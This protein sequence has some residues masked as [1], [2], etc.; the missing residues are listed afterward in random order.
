[1]AEIFGYLSALF[2]G[3]TLGLIGAGGS[4]LAVPVLVYLLGVAPVRATGYSLFIVGI[5]SLVGALQ[6]IRRDELNLRTGLRFAIPACAAVLLDRWLIV[7]ALPEQLF[8][9]GD[10][11]VTKDPAI[12]VFFAVIM[13]L[14]AFSM[15]RPGGKMPDGEATQRQNSMKLPVLGFGVGLVTGLVGAGGGF[16]IIPAL[17]LL[18]G[19]A[20]K[21]AVGTSLLIIAIN[22]L[23]G[24]SGDLAGGGIDWRLLAHFTAFAV[25]G[26]VFGSYLTRFIPGRKLKPA[27]GYFVLIMGVYILLREFGVF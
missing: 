19:L 27:F 20:M 13:L 8:T 15:I 12:M 17:V 26:I 23:V 14:S 7:P 21:E 9:L 3:V 25:A 5:T 2:V 6:Y 16:L 18:A 24:F 10:F 22:S 4:I 1:M 11:R